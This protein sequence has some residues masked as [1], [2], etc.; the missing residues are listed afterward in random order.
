[1]HI[2]TRDPHKATSGIHPEFS[3]VVRRLRY[4]L[5]RCSLDITSPWCVY[6]SSPLMVSCCEDLSHGTA[7]TRMLQALPIV[8]VTSIPLSSTA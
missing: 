2:R 7:G 5:S 8:A 4:I 3:F 6:R 1:M